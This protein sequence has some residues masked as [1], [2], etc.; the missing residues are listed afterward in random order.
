MSKG[1]F[2]AILFT[3]GAL[4]AAPAAYF[5]A[6]LGAEDELAGLR[7]ERSALAQRAETAENDRRNAHLVNEKLRS[8]KNRGDSNSGQIAADHE[9]LAREKGEASDRAEK[10]EAELRKLKN[11]AEDERRAA[12]AEADRL[13]AVLEKHNIYEHL[14]PEEIQARMKDGEER[15]KRAFDGKDKQALMKALGDL[16]KLGPSA[17]DKCIELWL[18][19]A[20]DFGLGENWGKGPNTLGLNFQEYVSLINNFELIKYGVTDSKVSD[21]FKINSLYG[22]PWW[23][24]EPSASRAKLAGDALLNSTGYTSQAAIEALRDIPDPGTV[25]YLSDYLG[26]NADNAE[27]RKS[28]IRVLAQKNTP[29]GWAAIEKAAASDSDEGVRQAAK[30]AQLTRNPKAT[31]VMITW[32]DPNGQGAVAGIRVGDIMTSYNGRPVKVLGDINEAKKTVLEGESA[33]VRIVRG[34]E[35]LELTLASG[36]IGINGVAVTAK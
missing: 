33:P 18:I 10:A 27:A 21:A 24:S 32:V 7:R 25:R 36:Q 34:D 30:Q 26:K 22:L 20:E 3:V 19:A 6:R 4:V 14:S 31:G 16:Q 17:Y 2:A 28:A 11:A 13:K 12:Q 15:F 9:R 23:T 1:V 35:T 5:F 29:E 8:E